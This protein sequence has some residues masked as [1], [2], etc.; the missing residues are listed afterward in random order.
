[1]ADVGLPYFDVLLKELS[2]DKRD[3][4]TAFG[5]HVHWGYWDRIDRADGSP[6]DFARAADRMS[7]RVWGA[8]GATDGQRILDV[9]CGFG[10]TIGL[11]DEALNDVELFGLNIDARQLARARQIVKPKE[12]NKATF[13]EGDACATPFDDASFDV[14]LAVE[15]AFHF[16]SRKRFF[17]EAKRVLKPGGRLALADI[18]PSDRARFL[19]P[20]KDILFSGYSKRLLGPAD[21]SYSTESY[22]DLARATGLSVLVEENVTKNTLP[23]YKLLRHIVRETNV[24]VKTALFGTGA[25]ELLGR[26]NI[27]QYVILSYEK[28]RGEAHDA[29]ARPAVPRSTREPRAAA[30]PD[31]V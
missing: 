17:S 15:C 26:L 18:V 21:L 20:M 1:M 5:R 29:P 23:T 4:A 10:G 27:L 14:V 2:A 30:I 9:G 16:P 28:P 6:A 31:G 19:S 22:R 25:M 24:H 13:V 3:I 12:A 11:L 8:A 7:E